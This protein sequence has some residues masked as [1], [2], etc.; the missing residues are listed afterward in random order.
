MDRLRFRHLTSVERPWVWA[1][2][3][4]LVFMEV[5]GCCNRSFSQVDYQNVDVPSFILLDWIHYLMA[6]FPQ[7]SW[8]TLKKSHC[9]SEWPHSVQSCTLPRWHL[10]VITSLLPGK[11]LTLYIHWRKDR[12]WYPFSHW[13]GF[14]WSLWWIS[15]RQKVVQRSAALLNVLIHI[16][17][18]V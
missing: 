18:N 3:S 11:L 16:W 14:W 12:K 17:R 4:S 8:V 13:N 9:C 2:L 10:G 5:S 1:L 7:V 15:M 6:L